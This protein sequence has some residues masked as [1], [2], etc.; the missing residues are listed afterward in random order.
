LSRAVD[1]DGCCR[2]SWEEAVSVVSLV[3]PQ[4]VDRLRDAVDALVAVDPVDLSDAALAHELVALRRQMDRQDAAFARLARAAHGRGLGSADG[5]AST[6]AWLRHRAGMR[7][8][9]AKAAIQS[10]EA[11]A[12]LGATGEA[13]RAG[14]IS[15]GAARTIVGARVDGHDDALLACEPALLDLAR[16]GDLR[17]LRRAAAHFRKLALADGSPPSVQ[18]GLYLARTFDGRTVVSGELDD[19][20]AET[21]TTALHAYTD[22][23]S[24]TDRRTTAR[25][26][27]AALVRICEVALE[28]TG[29]A[30]RPR[31]HVSV[32][33][34]WTTLTGGCGRADGEFTGPIHRRDIARLLCDCSVSRIVTGPDSLPLDVG[35]TRR[36]V[37][38]ALRRALVA[39]DGG[40]RFPGCDRPPGWCDAHHTVPWREG[41]CT[42]R[43]GLILL[44]DRHH[45]VVHQPG[46]SLD[47]D[48]THLV[49]RR[50]GGTVVT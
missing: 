20:A 14:E 15:T 48:G 2:T 34:D 3:A 21:V 22:P 24:D 46:W 38:P 4:P 26:R 42:T 17:S 30:R 31:A 43:D 7:E 18:D 27:A 11:C 37:P 25:R 19:L 13:W 10:G 41:G 6:A 39:R 35:R 45:H 29:D 40:C 49:I 12:V 32:V 44:C 16:R 23:P 50:P 8:G 28:R 36:T 1:R 5:A 9:D 47:F 33:L